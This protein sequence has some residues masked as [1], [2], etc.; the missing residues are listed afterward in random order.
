MV[1]RFFGMPSTEK[2]RMAD[3]ADKADAEIR[4]LAAVEGIELLTLNISG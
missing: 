1:L 4:Q 2:I 3:S